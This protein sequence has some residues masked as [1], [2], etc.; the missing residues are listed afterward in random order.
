MKTVS[1]WKWLCLACVA[2]L[3]CVMVGL[4]LFLERQ[5]LYPEGVYIGEQLYALDYA[6]TQDEQSLGLGGREQ[7][8]A[9]CAMAFPFTIPGKYAFWMKDMRFAL[10]IVWIS[11]DGRVVH[12]EHR[13]APE[14]QEVYRS[15][16]PATLVLEFNAG[17]L[18]TVSVGDSL[19]FFSPASGEASF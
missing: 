16:E 7:L 9:T 11:Q 2:V 10:D 1:H 8:C 4:V 18:D 14:S 13:I 3:G 17:T 5:T 15:K 19:R 6:L 12:I